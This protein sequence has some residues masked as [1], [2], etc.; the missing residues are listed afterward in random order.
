MVA[1]APAIT[2]AE[3]LKKTQPLSEEELKARYVGKLI[4]L[5]GSYMGDELN[6]DKEGKITGSPAVS[7]FTL[8]GFEVRKI[9]LSKHKLDIEAD[10]YGLH[11][12]GALPFDDDSKTY[13]QVKIS[14]KPVHISIEREEIVI[15]KVKKEKKKKKKAEPTPA[16]LAAA[17]KL[18]SRDAAGATRWY[19]NSVSRRAESSTDLCGRRRDG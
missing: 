7:S 19:G 1:A 17:Q 11:F 2:E 8:S 18:K 13:D 6:F 15:P 4:F 14:N 9:E 12:F 16:E 3:L 10:R 5:R